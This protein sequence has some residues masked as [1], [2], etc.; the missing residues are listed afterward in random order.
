MSIK[1]VIVEDNKE[2]C[3]GLSFLINSSEGFKCIAKFYDAENAFNEIPILCP[4]VILMDIHLPKM[5]GIECITKLRELN[6]KS[7][8]IMLTIFEDDENIFNSLQAGAN[9][10]LLKKTPPAQLLEAIK[11]IHNGG[12]PMSSQIA[13]KV[14]NAFQ[15]R[16]EMTE[17]A[18]SLS[19]REKEL[20]ELLAKGY[21]Y[22]EIAEKL[23]I[24]VETV[25]THIRNIYEKLQVHS[26]T[27]ALLK[28]YQD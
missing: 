28:V 22:K 15:K 12:S 4:D 2:I 27:E 11:D 20:L 18:S 25:R 1:V 14:V 10:Y 26:R 21:R 13:R 24:S 16:N 19:N 6:I 9:G 7:Q 23:F 3:E 17:D 5:S 8:I